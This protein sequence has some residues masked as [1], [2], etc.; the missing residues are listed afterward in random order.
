MDELVERQPVVDI[1]GQDLKLWE[2]GHS[3]ADRQNR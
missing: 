1:H 3:A 2:G